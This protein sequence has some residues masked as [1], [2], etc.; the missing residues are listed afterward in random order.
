MSGSLALV[1]HAHL[2]FVRHPEHDEFFEEDWL[3]EAIS[4]TYIPLLAMMQRLVRDGVPFKLTLGLTPPLCAMLRTSCCAPAISAISSAPFV[5]RSAK[6]NARATSHAAGTRAL[7][8][9]IVHRN[10][11]P[12]RGGGLRSHRRVSRVARCGR[13]RTH[14]LRRDARFA[15]AACA[16]AGSGAGADSNR[17]RCL[18]TALR[19]EPVG[20][21]LPECAYAPGLEKILQAENLRWFIV[22]AHACCSPNHGRTAPFMRPVSPPPD[23]RSSRAIR[24]PAVRSGA[25]RRV[26][27]ANQF[28]GISI[29]TS[30]LISRPIMFGGSCPRLRASLV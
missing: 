10:P 1:L 3:F 28:I 9:P 29:G 8:S 22:D 15:P 5:W 21:W 25:L 19:A 24:F 2:P 14:G 23:R 26:I 16:F 6:S 11:T 27:R 18:P 12:L 13:A 30:G 4:E 7:L 20:F 17:L